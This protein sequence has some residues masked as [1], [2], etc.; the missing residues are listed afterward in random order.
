M[1]LNANAVET[2]L[3]SEQRRELIQKLWPHLQKPPSSDNDLHGWQAYFQHYSDEVRS[4]IESDG[5]VNTTVRMHEDVIAI[6]SSLEQRV[7]KHVIKKE[8]FLLDTQN[9]SSAEKERMAEGSIKLVV[10]LL[11]MVDIGPV[12]QNHIPSLTYVPWVEE[13][14]DVG[15]VLSQH[16]QKSKEDAGKVRFDSKFSAYNLERLA[17]V[18]IVWTN[19]LAD[20][21]RLVE[22]DTKL[23]IFHQTTFLKSQDGTAIPEGLA[24]ETLRTLALLFPSRSKDRDAQKWL[25]SKLSDKKNSVRLDSDLL[26]IASLRLLDRKA[27]KFEYW[28]S[29]LL[30]LKEIFDEPRPTSMRRLWHD[31][32]NKVQWATFWVAMLILGLT[33][34]FGLVQS[35]EGALQ[36]EKAYHPVQ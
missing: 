13:K 3:T 29:E 26:N 28:R 4:A 14:Y 24:E 17:G 27:E 23:C 35:I 30:T 5:G 25:R 32:R 33:I 9:R 1:A 7:A 12:S 36:V 8:L 21:L 6:A 15:T 31:R 10:R 18:K 34:F 20:H 2:P 16:F 11:Y 22:D 19:N